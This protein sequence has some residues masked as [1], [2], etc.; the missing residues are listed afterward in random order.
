MVFSFIHCELVRMVLS[1]EPLPLP[2]F[3]TSRVFFWHN[4][5]V[6]GLYFGSL[7]CIKRHLNTCCLQI[8]DMH[9]STHQYFRLCFLAFV[10]KLALFPS[11]SSA[12]SDLP[13]PVSIYHL[14][15]TVSHKRCIELGDSYLITSWAQKRRGNATLF[16]REG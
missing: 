13:L 16:E 8:G 9:P 1:W 5:H 11:F 7:S 14:A 4:Q 10:Q 12:S 6:Q 15:F 3:Q 2:V